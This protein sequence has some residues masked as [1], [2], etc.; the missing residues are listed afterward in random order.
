MSVYVVSHGCVEFAA[1]SCRVRRVILRSD[2]VQ[3]W[4]AHRRPDDAAAG[5][6]DGQRRPV[7]KSSRRRSSAAAMSVVCD[8]CY[9]P[10]RLSG[11]SVYGAAHHRHHERRGNEQQ[12]DDD[13]D[14]ERRGRRRRGTVHCVAQRHVDGR[15]QV[16]YVMHEASK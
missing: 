4:T 13:D 11:R 1:D 7:L 12:S 9:P 14:D 10:A 15:L 5:G 3:R 8:G 6:A 16:R 2:V